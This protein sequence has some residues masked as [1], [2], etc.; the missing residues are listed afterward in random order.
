MIEGI[1]E[2]GFEFALEDD[3]LDDYELLEILQE[4]DSGDALKITE[5]AKLL[6]GEKQLKEL[7]EH[8]KGDG[9]RV[10][11]KKMISSIS[12]IMKSCNKGKN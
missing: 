12:E 3:A 2:S 6:L 8:I 1:T 11:A 10:S 9:K 5:A 7:K 4:V